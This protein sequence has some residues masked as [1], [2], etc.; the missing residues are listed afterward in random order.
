M[1]PASPAEANMASGESYF[2]VGPGAVIF[3]RERICYIASLRCPQPMNEFNMFSIRRLNSII[4]LALLATLFPGAALPQADPWTLTHDVSLV[5]RW[6]SASGLR[7]QVVTADLYRPR[8]EGRVPAAVI[9]NS[10]GGIFPATEIYY[11]RLFAQNGLASLVIDSFMPRGVRHIM[12]DHSRV[13]SVQQDADAISGLNWLAGQSWVD[14]QRIIVIGMSRGGF[15]ALRT[16]LNQ[17]RNL[18]P[19]TDL[20]FAA[21]VAVAPGGC[22]FQAV[23]PKTTGAPIFFML[24]ELD[25]GTPASPCVDFAD[26]MRSGGNRNVRVAMYPGVH[27]GY[28][29]TGGIYRIESEEED[30]KCSGRYFIDGNA[31]LIDRT[32]GN[33]VTPPGGFTQ[34]WRKT[35]VELGRTVGGDERVK[36]Q[37]TADLLQFLRDAEIIFDADA[38][39]VVP[40]CTTIANGIY[41]DNCTRARNGWTGDLVAL[42]RAYRYP[43]GVTRD[44]ALAKRLFR[45]AADRDNGPAQ[46]ELA[47]MLWNGL[48]GSRDFVAASALAQRAA[49]LGECAAMNLLGVMARDGD[50]RPRDE[51]EAVTWFRKAADL[52]HPFGLAQDFRDVIDQVP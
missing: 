14:P 52:R 2:R 51:T 3:G 36:A 17:Y 32:S 10:S 8:M 27:H 33:R 38:R 7:E 37:A 21:H 12:D 13:L 16:A 46:M 9:I 45:L 4:R 26:R 15:I 34:W 31:R 48:G 24:A 49:A 40:D 18:L 25:D 28:E 47:D 39:T 5:S 43:G 42:G 6:P 35:C 1:S 20:K 23:D 50:G 30:P 22:T 19:A 11:A 29:S 44:D 41:R